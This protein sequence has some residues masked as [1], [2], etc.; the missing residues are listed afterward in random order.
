LAELYNADLGLHGELF[1]FAPDLFAVL[2]ADGNER[3]TQRELAGLLEA[4]PDVVVRVDYALDSA[5][6]LSLFRL[7]DSLRAAGADIEQSPGRLF[8]S[9]PGSQLDLYASDAVNPNVRFA[10]AQARFARLD[11]SNDLLL[12]GQE[13]AQAMPPVEIDVARFDKNNDEKLSIAEIRGELAGKPNY[14][15]VQLRFRL[16]EEGD[17]LM[18]WLDEKPDGRLTSRELSNAAN[19]LGD[20]DS[21]DDGMVV[22][23]E[24]PD[25]LTCAIERGG[26]AMGTNRQQ[27][28]PPVALRPAD[29]PVMPG[30]L[31]AM[32]QNGDGEISRREFL[33]TT[34]QFR[35]LDASTDGFLT[36]A[37]AT[38]AESEHGDVEKLPG[39][40]AAEPT[41]GS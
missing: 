30:W 29:R 27:P 18:G 32:D 1:V 24:I 40:D 33:G 17:P 22:A 13:L 14:R 35:R 26:P 5:P 23:S 34:D 38:A 12:D 36:A 6:Q 4:R 11:T 7:A 31:A 8:I 19:R 16:A 37:E 41:D 21:N 9:L 28:S 10:D 2:D 20:L 15:D 25:R 39:P 3:V